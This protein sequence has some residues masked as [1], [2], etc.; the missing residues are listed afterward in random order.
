[1]VA[2]IEAEDAAESDKWQKVKEKKQASRRRPTRIWNR[3]DTFIEAHAV[4]AEH[5]HEHSACCKS[6]IRKAHNQLFSKEQGKLIIL[7]VG[8]EIEPSR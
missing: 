3:F 5:D 6:V 8:I 1:M 7:R 2:N 4:E